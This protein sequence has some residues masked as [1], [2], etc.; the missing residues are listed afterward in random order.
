MM[1][2][3]APWTARPLGCE[4][5]AGLHA[6]ETHEAAL[7]CEL[8]EASTECTCGGYLVDG[9]VEHDGSCALYDASP[10]CECGYGCTSFNGCRTP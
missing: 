5:G 8:V 10:A 7:L 4:C 2:D 6:G 1:L 9:E 3:V